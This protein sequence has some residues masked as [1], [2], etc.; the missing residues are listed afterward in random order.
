M[1]LKAV[2]ENVINKDPFI[3]KGFFVKMKCFSL[4]WSDA[5]ITSIPFKRLSALRFTDSCIYYLPTGM[6]LVP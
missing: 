5:I 2:T 3:L 4:P 6:F 1:S